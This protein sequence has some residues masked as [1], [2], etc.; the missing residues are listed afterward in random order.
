MKQR[1][2]SKVG[3]WDCLIC[4]A[5]FRV[6]RELEDH[7]RSSHQTH[8]GEQFHIK[9]LLKCQ[10]CGEEKVRTIEGLHIHEKYCKC[11]PNRVECIG[12]LHTDEEKKHLS[13]LAKEQKFGGWHTSKKYVYNG[14]RLDSTYEVTFAQDLDLNGVKWER[15]EPLTYKLNEDEHRYYPDF[16]LPEQNV[17][18]D[19]KNDF[20]INN[21]NPRFG[22]TD[23]E[24]IKLVEQQND[25]KVLIL[26]KNNL[27]WEAVKLKFSQER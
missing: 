4:G 13:D 9:Q 16:Y 5:H 2:D 14:I 20:L 26:D 7:K 11:N 22:I 6:R 27:S 23:V 19:T 3:G 21:I 15:P 24:K 10:F 25:V 12:H 8:K 1:K 18:V 17:F